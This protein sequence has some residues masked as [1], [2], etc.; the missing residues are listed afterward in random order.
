MSISKVFTQL[1]DFLQLRCLELHNIIVHHDDEV[2]L[3]QLIA[4]GSRLTRL[5]YNSRNNHTN[6]LITVF[7]QQSSLQEL[8]LVIRAW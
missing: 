2:I 4:P 7:L 3:H 5:E 1:R 8:A 6:S